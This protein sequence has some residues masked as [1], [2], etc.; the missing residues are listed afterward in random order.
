MVT[1][2][3]PYSDFT[4]CASCL[5]VKRLGSQKN[6]ADLL[7]KLLQGVPTKD[8]KARTGWKNAPVTKMWRG[9]DDLLMVYF[10]AMLREWLNRGYRSSMVYKK[11]SDNPAVPFWYGDEKLHSSHR[12]VLLYKNFEWYSRFGWTE[13]PEYAYYWPV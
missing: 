11:P 8:S 5:D 1:T 9:Y 7:I 10:N 3:L 13:K 12:K 6:E 2:F 4:E